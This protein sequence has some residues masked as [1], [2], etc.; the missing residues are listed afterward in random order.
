MANPVDGR[1]SSGFRRLIA[2]LS[3]LSGV[4][5]LLLVLP[6]VAD[7]AHRYFIGSSLPGM[8]EYS[9]VGIV[10]VVYLGVAQALR[11]GAHIST[12]IVTARLNPVTAARVRLAGSMLLWLLILFG[13]WRTT[14]A[15]IEAT[16]IREF[17][18]GSVMVST[19]PARICVALG[20]LL[21]LVELSIEIWQRLR[22][23]AAA[24][25]SQPPSID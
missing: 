11:D 9:E 22:G 2:S 14:L 16:H 19:W 21:L 24:G 12:P 6:T 17:R 8:V 23:T 3:W 7:V 20:F 15:A 5:I 10:F 25:P 13:T 4:G 1:W 18:F